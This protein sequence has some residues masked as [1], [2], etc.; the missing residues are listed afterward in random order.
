MSAPSL[1]VPMTVLALGL[2]GWIQIAGS[3]AA[4]PLCVTGAVSPAAVTV[5]LGAGVVAA[6]EMLTVR[7]TGSEVAVAPSA[8]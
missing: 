5:P 8:A 4:S 2:L 3:S 1:S 7:S 6:A